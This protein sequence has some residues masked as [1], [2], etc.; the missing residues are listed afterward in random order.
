M[1]VQELKRVGGSLFLFIKL[2]QA[3]LT[4]DDDFGFKADDPA[5]GKWKLSDCA[6][7]RLHDVDPIFTL[8]PH[9]NYQASCKEA[10][11]NKLDP[12]L[13]SMGRHQFI[14]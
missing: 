12:S 3:P 1:R 7:P 13:K 2:D 8:L 10:N 6:A 11:V 5:D 14:I 9:A 4:E